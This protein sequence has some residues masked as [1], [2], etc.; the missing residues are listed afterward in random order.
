MTEPNQE[1]QAP[2]LPEEPQLVEE[3]EVAQMSEIATL[4]N[5][6]LE[7]GRTFEDLRRG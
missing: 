6:F 2:P 7:P 3:K 5:I 1:W 4:G